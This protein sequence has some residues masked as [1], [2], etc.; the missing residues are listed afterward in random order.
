MANKN[1]R[2]SRAGECD[3]HIIP[4]TGLGLVVVKKCINL[5][6]G[7]IKI[8]SLINYGATCLVMLPFKVET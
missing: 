7:D 6:Q 3:V 8:T 5:H 2:S 4:G 1:L